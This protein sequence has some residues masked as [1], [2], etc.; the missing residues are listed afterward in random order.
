[1]REWSLDKD[2]AGL[3]E[4]CIANGTDAPSRSGET[5]SV[6]GRTL[7]HHMGSGFPILTT[8]R[9]FYKGVLG[10]LSAFLEGA[11][12]LARFKAL[13]CN[14]WDMNAGGQDDLGRI[15]GAQWRGFRGRAGE[16][17]QLKALVAG[18]KHDPFSR[19]HILLTWHPAELDQMC[20]PPCYLIHQYNVSPDGEL[21]SLVYMRSV[22]ICLGLPSDLVLSGV[23]QMLVARQTNL[24]PG[25]LVFFMGNAHVYKNHFD[26]CQ[27]QLARSTR[28]VNG[29]PPQV[30]LDPFADLFSFNPSDAKVINYDP[31]GALQYELN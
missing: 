6:F 2:L 23:L 21:D 25:R 4:D 18:I 5:R 10:E 31:Q 7:E 24:I 1:M 14:Y 30:L 28:F 22:D 19:R 17:D 15:Y 20:L 16:V 29:A 3:I 11:T 27:T 13:G 9:I 26:T 8:R 12:S